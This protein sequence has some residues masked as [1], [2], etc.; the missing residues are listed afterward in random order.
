MFWLLALPTYPNSFRWLISIAV[1][2]F[3]NE[4]FGY[5]KSWILPCTLVGA[6]AYSVLAFVPP[7]LSVVYLIAG[8]L[9]FKAIVMVA[10]D[11]AIDAYAAEAM[12]DSRA[13][14]RHLDHQ[15]AGRG[16]RCRGRRHGYVGRKIRMETHD[17]RR[18][19]A[20]C[21]SRLRRP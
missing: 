14:D 16:R 1:D 5:R 10:Q 3:G 6:L 15:L 9:V 18:I 2:N 20:P 19:V 21:F 12:N 7:S 8:I 17:A 11:T 13:A 4:R